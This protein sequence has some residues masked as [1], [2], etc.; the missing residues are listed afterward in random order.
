MS[1]RAAWYRTVVLI[2]GLVAA[3]KLCAAD[4]T[5]LVEFVDERGAA[6][7]AGI[8][9]GDKITGW[10]ARP[11]SGTALNSSIVKSL[12]DPF[13]LFDLES[14]I[15]PLS[16]IVLY[17]QRGDQ[18]M[19][20]E[21]GKT[22]W[23][24]RTQPVWD[25]SDKRQFGEIREALKADNV[26]QAM[27][28]TRAFAGIMEKE[29][30]FADSAWIRSDTAR[31]FEGSGK[32]ALAEQLYREAID[33]IANT[34]L[35]KIR[36]WLSYRQG[37]ALMRRSEFDMANRVF[38]EALELH[39]SISPT[40]FGVAANYIKFGQ[41]ARRRSDFETARSNIEQ[42]LQL[43][44]RLSPD[45]MLVASTLNELG[46]VEAHS[47]NLKRASEIF[48]R[49]LAIAET[50]DPDGRAAA[51]YMNSVAVTLYMQGDEAG[52][53]ELWLRS[54]EIKSALEP[55]SANVARVL[56]NVALI[57]YNRGDY[58]QSESLYLRALAITEKQLPDSTETAKTWNNLGSLALAQGNY[59]AAQNY[60]RKAYEL[61]LAAS[62]DS[63]DFAASLTNLANVARQRGR[64]EE[65]AGLYSD[66]LKIQERLDPA[67]SQTALLWINIGVLETDREN[68]EQALAAYKKGQ[69]IYA[70]IAPTGRGVAESSLKIGEHAL[71]RA[72]HQEAKAHFEQAL[73]I[74]DNIGPDTF[75]QARA[76]YGLAKIYW[77]SGQASLA[78]EHFEKSL[79]ALESQH[80]RLGGTEETRATSRA[81]HL[82]PFNDYIDFLLEH[83]EY[84]RAFDILERSRSRVLSNLLSE[85]DLVFYAD[86]PDELERERRMLAKNYENTQRELY[87]AE[88][89]ERAAS[90]LKTMQSTRQMQDEIARQIREHSPRLADLKYSLPATLGEI[91]AGL[92]PG[93]AVLSYSVGEVKTRVFAL[94]ASGELKV[95]TL[96]LGRAD[97]DALTQRFRYLIDAGRWD[98]AASDSLLSFASSLY[99]RLML[100]A[101]ASIESADRLLIVPD[102]SLN[103]LPFAALVRQS[104]SGRNQYVA[105]WRPSLVVSSLTVQ[106]QLRR[107]RS[108][109][110]GSALVA[111]GNPDYS[112]APDFLA[113]R[114]SLTSNADRSVLTDLPWSGREV[115]SIAEVYREN[116]TIY[117]GRNAS[118]EKAKAVTK[119]SARYIHFAAH[120]L[121]NESVPLDTAIALAMPESPDA[122][123]DNGFLQVWEVYES[124]RIN[125]DLVTLSGC[126]T[127]LGAHYAGEG[128][129]GLTRAFQYA[130]AA[131]VL[132]SLWKVN[133]R[134]TS[135]FMTHFYSRLAE[136]HSQDEAL[137]FAQI[138]MIRGQRAG[139]RSWL[140]TVRSWFG[141]QSEDVNLAH[142]YRWAGFVLNGLGE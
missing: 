67:S 105:Q 65:A 104:E 37:L 71:A 40:R 125:A 45:S 2:L 36:A 15:H 20:F 133:D 44:E 70:A 115:E 77:R 113:G 119:N 88:N 114:G 107:A 32:H 79:T 99:A 19:T 73:S 47:G 142:P 58:A 102:G 76:F 24:L 46:Q 140:A 89:K 139:K 41:I 34:N 132:A 7:A 11:P 101:E 35:T 55:D 82:E 60:H 80:A 118:E 66:A 3:S 16:P 25:A 61:R 75:P 137:Q 98:E 48:H 83:G 110:P 69:A 64:L 9:T 129:L 85:R 93:T 39:R 10:S 84:E 28:L 111:F 122:D 6:E 63:I 27:E 135:Q 78:R 1:F 90:L 123:T 109:T 130:G 94:S 54:L 72:Q 86:I 30:R 120:A 4:L 117:T 136:G 81:K 22:R 87:R 138:A 53:E 91:R 29:N 121:L 8:L 100:P 126:E 13:A 49:A 141:S 43:Q 50:Q 14:E 106:L 127:A 97:I 95:H 12:E 124:L 96:E 59:I 5:L 92:R 42:G 74:L 56:H 23:R 51:G 17:G 52:A 134:S 128:L 131:S 21:L 57:K 116:A 62:P 38:S 112:G 103:L 68:L 33:A 18:A 108:P 26:E 31:S